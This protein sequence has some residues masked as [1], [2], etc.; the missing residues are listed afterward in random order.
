M[1]VITKV[2]GETFSTTQIIIIIILL[3]FSYGVALIG[4]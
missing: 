4:D 3:L 2:L 1:S